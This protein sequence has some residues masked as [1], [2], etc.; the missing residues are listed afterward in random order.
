MSS[1]VLAVLALALLVGVWLIVAQWSGTDGRGDWRPTEL[2]R[3]KLA[4]IERDLS[5]QGTH[6]VVGR[7]DQVWRLKNGRHVPVELKTRARQIVWESDI[8]ELSLQAWLLRQCGFATTSHGWVVIEDIGSHSKSA[9]RVSLWSD[10]RCQ[11]AIDRH[12]AIRTAAA[13]PKKVR[14]PKCRKCAYQARCWA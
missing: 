2:R 11:A 12:V 13:A 8:A 5:V 14:G 6:L 1:T 7:P 4:H 10:Q 3:A 9:H